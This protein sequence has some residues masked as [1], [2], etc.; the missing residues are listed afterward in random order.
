MD[1]EKI[2]KLF[3]YIDSQKD[4]YIEEL[5]ELLSYPSLSIE[6]TGMLE[7]AQAVAR[8]MKKSGFEGKVNKQK[9]G[10]PVVTGSTEEKSRMRIGIYG[11]YDVYPTGDLSG[12]ISHPF[13]PE[14]RKGKLYG[15]GATD[16]KGNMFANI[17]AAEA[18]KKVFGSLP[19]DLFFLFEGEEE[20]GSKSLGGFLRKNRR[21]FGNLSGFIACDRGWHETGRP[22]IFLGCKSNLT[23]KLTVRGSKRDVHSGQS[24]LIPNPAWKLVHLL[25]KIVGEDGEILVPPLGK[26]KQEPSKRDLS[27]LKNIPFDVKTYKSNYGIK[28][29]LAREKPFDALKKL[30]FGAIWNISNFLAGTE[31]ANCIVPASATATMD[32]RISGDYNPYKIMNS[33]TRFVKKTGDV[34]I[35]AFLTH[36]YRVSIA[37]PFVSKVVSVIKETF[38]EKPVVWP[39]WDGAGPLGVLHRTFD[40]PAMIIGLGAP[41]SMAHTHAM[42]EFIRVQD[43]TNGIKLMASVFAKLS[44]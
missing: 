3:T 13:K 16:D 21:T 8:L 7:G 31:E 17:K 12:W 26:E 36:G 15:R 32:L 20:I 6:S 44:E 19:I 9:N 28:K 14:V 25:A 43:I 10:N 33:L 41:F 29:I 2:R 4:R 5:S 37:D 24:P 40:V 18:V 1:R 38:G 27:I 34:E 11:H 39:Q 23:V 35:S 22:Q 42:N 30:T